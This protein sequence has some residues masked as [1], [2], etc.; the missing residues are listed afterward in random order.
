MFVLASCDQTAEKTTT[1]NQIDVASA[2]DATPFSEH[3][4]YTV[5][6]TVI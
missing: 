6:Q 4:A 2:A 3:T 1:S 5:V